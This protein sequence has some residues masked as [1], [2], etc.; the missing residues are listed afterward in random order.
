[1]LLLSSP[2]PIIPSTNNSTTIKLL[3]LTVTSLLTRAALAIPTTPDTPASTPESYCKLTDKEIVKA[4]ASALKGESLSINERSID[5][6]QG[7]GVNCGQEYY[8]KLYWC[9]SAIA[10]RNK[11]WQG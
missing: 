9:S 11:V 10:G 2:A 8:S 5:R 7:V 1:M 3:N 4:Q 6:R